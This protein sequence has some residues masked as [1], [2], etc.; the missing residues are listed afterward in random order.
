[1]VDI[2]GLGYLLNPDSREPR[3]Y[4]DGGRAGDLGGLAAAGP[5]A[6]GRRT[7]RVARLGGRESPSWPG[8]T[9]V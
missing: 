6:A 5:A 9:S 1:M 8:T 4:R 7:R 2:N 3:R